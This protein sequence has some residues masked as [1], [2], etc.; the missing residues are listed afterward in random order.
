MIYN[1]P[2]SLSNILD[3]DYLQKCEGDVRIKFAVA[4][5]QKLS[6]CHQ[7]IQSYKI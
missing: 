6:V 4:F 2:I 7:N 1:S 5:V 3:V